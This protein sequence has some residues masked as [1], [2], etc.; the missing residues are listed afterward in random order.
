MER[1]LRPASSGNIGEVRF[2]ASYSLTISLFP[3]PMHGLCPLCF[4]LSICSLFSLQIGLLVFIYSSCT[5]KISACVSFCLVLAT[6]Q[7]GQL[8]TLP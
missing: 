6:L 7:S 4:P 2:T 5:S 3:F 8:L 1:K